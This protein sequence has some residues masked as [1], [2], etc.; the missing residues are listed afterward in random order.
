MQG[1]CL[2][3]YFI[4]MFSR[5]TVTGSQFHSVLVTG[6]ELSSS[7]PFPSALSL[8]GAVGYKGDVGQA[9]CFSITR[10]RNKCHLLLL[11]ESTVSL[12]RG[13]H[14][15]VGGSRGTYYFKVWD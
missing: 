6:S 5:D 8:K 1:Q 13:G 12:R 3:D 14:K 7:L 4:Y 15:H 9:G 2:H 11:K 10:S